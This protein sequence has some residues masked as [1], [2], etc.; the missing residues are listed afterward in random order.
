VVLGNYEARGERKIRR[1]RLGINNE[2][3]RCSLIQVAVVWACMLGFTAPAPAPPV[4]VHH[5][6]TVTLYPEEQRL[7]G[8]DTLSLKACAGDEVLLTLASDARIM[9]VYI[10]ERATTFIFKDGQLQ[11]PVP[12]SFLEKEFKIAVSY[13]TFFRDPVPRDPVYTEDPTYSVTGVISPEGTLLLSESGWYPDLP[14]GK[15]T[16]HVRV[17]APAGY[18]AVTAGKRLARNTKGDTTSSIWKTT[19]PMKGLSLSAGP[20]LVRHAQTRGV[21]IYT[22][23]FAE[24][25]HLSKQY[26]EGTAKYLNLYTALLGPYPFEKFAVVE[27]FFPTGYG[28][29][30]YTLL[31]RTVIRLPFILET[32]LGHEVSHAWWGSGVFVDHGQGNWSE[33]LTT[34]VADHLFKERSSAREGRAYRLK[35]LRDYAT[36]V[37]AEKDFPLQAFTNRT[38]PWTSAVGYGKGAM[39]F[40]M[41]RRLVGDE[42]FWAGLREVFRR[43]LFQPASWDDFALAL[44]CTSRC[45]LKPFFRQWVARPGAPRLALQD[46]KATKKKE[47]WIITGRLSQQAPFYDLEVPLRVETEGRDID[48]KVFLTGQ[49]APFGLC[50]KAT[51][52]RLVV[53]PDVDLFRRLYPE[54]IPPIINGIKGSSSLVA[55]VARNQSTETLEGSRILLEAFGQKDALIL[56]E[57]EVVPEDLKGHDVLYLGFPETQGYMLSL[58]PSLSVSPDRFAL[59]GIIYDAPGHAMFVVLPHPQDPERVAGLFLPLSS[60]AAV[61]AARKI[62]HYGKYSYLAFLGG[63]NQVKGTWPVSASPLIHVFP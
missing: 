5:D 20:Y 58:P 62:A 4:S 38:S 23:F 59:D 21:P 32:S 3:V 22:Y 24:D 12:E 40:H 11:I 13:E 57:D 34:Y 15:P 7:R 6:L 2:Y 61:A 9:D 47:G 41:A 17:C 51:P 50:L 1:V 53:D 46:L 60:E 55:V 54:E 8:A 36:L 48:T 31:G 10:A 27:N 39:V 63:M 43:K 18:E 52:R 56:S 42:A 19:R 16:F 44:E 49:E 28:F 14:G 37:S 25:D 29:P 30:S 33:G 35:I 45:N 26:L